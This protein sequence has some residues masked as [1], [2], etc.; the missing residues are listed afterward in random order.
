MSR[1]QFSAPIEEIV[2]TLAGSV[3]QDSYM[4][5]QIR[6]RVSPRNPQS[7]FQQLRRGE[8]GYLSS[9]WRNLT[10]PQQQTWIDEAGSVNM[11]FRL[12][13]GCN[14][15]LTLVEIDPVSSFIP[16][17]TPDS[18]PLEIQQYE[19]STIQV[20]AV[21]SSAVVPVNHKLL[22]F[23]TYEKGATKIF[24]NPSQYGPI[25]SFP[26]GTDF[27]VPVDVTALWVSRY[28]IIRDGFQICI[29]SV[30]VN[31]TNGLRGADYV[32]CAVNPFIAVDS[33]IDS[34]GTFLINSDGT[35]ITAL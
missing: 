30:L 5:V 14:I 18:L 17:A 29:K 7:Y 6:T 2:G 31:T 13:I 16:S 23:A 1:I 32:F 27:S 24:T 20:S 12:Y 26:A 11:G 25:G 35:F 9:G 8:F 22:L 34:D 10:A 21:T 4:G 28:G 15:N 19:S 33:L 3:F